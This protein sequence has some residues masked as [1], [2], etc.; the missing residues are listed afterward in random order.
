MSGGRLRYISDTL[1]SVI[2]NINVDTPERRVLV[3]YLRDVMVP[4]LRAVEWNDSGDG[5][6][7][8]LELMRM[9]IP[10]EFE[11]TAL[12]EELQDV[13]R[14]AEDYLVRLEEV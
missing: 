5:D 7:R 14:A 10:L 1:D 11:K 13:I 3:K 12:I 9:A 8:E 4:L 6:P 2:D